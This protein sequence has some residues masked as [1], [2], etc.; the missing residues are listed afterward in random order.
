MNTTTIYFAS[1]GLGRASIS[2]ADADAICQRV[3]NVTASNGDSLSHDA[4][5]AELDA[6]AD[7]ATQELYAI[8]VESAEVEIDE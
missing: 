6:T 4:V 7:R 1:H 3:N 8:T 5:Q 2:T